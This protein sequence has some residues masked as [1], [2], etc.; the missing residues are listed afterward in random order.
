LP[1]IIAPT[2]I[3]RLDHPD[4]ELAL[5]RA[6]ST[7]GT[8]CAISHMSGYEI[9]DVAAAATGP[10]WQQL[11]WTFGRDG[12]ED[13]IERA[14]L[15]GYAG[16]VVT[17]DLASGGSPR[18]ALP[19]RSWRTAAH[20]LPQ[21]VGRVRWL[22]RFGFGL[23]LDPGRA[24]RPIPGTPSKALSPTWQDLEWI[25]RRWDGPLI[26]KGIQRREDAR[27]AI[28]VGADAVVVS[29]HGG[30]RLDGT[31]PTLSLLPGVVSELGSEAVVLLDGGIRRGSDVA[32]ALAMGAKAVLVGRA[33]MFGLAAAGERGVSRVMEI[34][35]AELE[36]AL[37]ALGCASLED[38]DP[39]LVRLPQD[40]AAEQ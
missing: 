10:K 40:W 9:E 20:Y 25:R 28:E 39:S 4:G 8:I 24:L 32:K 23:R 37:L 11:F 1:V 38:L 17:V 15:S 6:A 12:A 27:R 33:T 16:L 22:L 35:R 26:V 7:A 29:N 18:D 30:L 2:G 31:A 3:P 5:A 19:P 13:V 36:T 34:F 14:S 21:T